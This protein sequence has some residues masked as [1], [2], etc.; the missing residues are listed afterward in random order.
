MKNTGT[1]NVLRFVVPLIILV[2]G[3]AAAAGLVKMRPQAKR[4]AP[5]ATAP[6]VHVLRVQPAAQNARVSGTG[7]VSAAREVQIAPEVA[8]RVTYQSKKLVPGGR[9][10]AGE[11]LLR[12]DDR[13]YQI[14]IRQQES[15][16][17]KAQLEL[18]VELGRQGVAKKEWELLGDD[19]PDEAAKLALRKPYLASAQRGLDSANS[20]LER[21]QLQLERT[22]L[23]A[24][25]NAL[26][27]NEGVEVG[28]YVG[29][30]ARV[31]TLIGTDEFW[32]TVS[33][34]MERLAG[35]ELAKDGKPGSK[36]I[37]RQDLGNAGV[38]ER[39]GSVLRLAG[40]LDPQTRTAQVIVAVPNPLDGDDGQ[41][42]L[43]VGAFVEVEI[44]GRVLSDVYAIP[45]E[46]LV[47][48]D[49]VWIVDGA[50]TLQRRAVQLAWRWDNGGAVF[51]GEGLVPDDRVVTTPLALPIAGQKVRIVEEKTTLA[52]TG[53][54]AATP[55]APAAP[56]APAKGSGDE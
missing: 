55:A 20:G 37:V 24:P 35:V 4:G 56:A 32:V 13:D 48:G 9:F 17:G 27:T 41:L 47:D 2:A 49:Q 25:F 28:Q 52:A 31:A 44:T 30:G 51:V 16:V 39:E 26:V 23:A 14:A 36:A 5:E 10:K 19:R 54:Q 29:P 34:P 43:L 38:I 8:G 18:D 22:R 21:A 7:V 11:V 33:L 3:V 50:G 1:S 46:A 42:P 15:L 40:Q 45:R 12:L 6:A 53:P